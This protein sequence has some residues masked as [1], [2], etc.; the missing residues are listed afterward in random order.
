MSGECQSL[1][2]PSHQPPPQADRE[3][4]DGHDDHEELDEAGPL[5]HE[6][7]IEIPDEA[8]LRWYFADLIPIYG[9]ANLR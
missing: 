2:G 8:L 4:L 3:Q 7:P 5:F 6:E 9:T 1:V